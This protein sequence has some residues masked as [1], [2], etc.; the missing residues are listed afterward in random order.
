LRGGAKHLWHFD[1]TT[2]R[3]SNQYSERLRRLR[4]LFQGAF[5]IVDQEQGLLLTASATAWCS[6]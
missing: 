1:L 6:P 4:S 5:V 2:R 3:R